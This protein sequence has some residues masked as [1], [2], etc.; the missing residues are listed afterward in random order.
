VIQLVLEF[1]LLKKNFNVKLFWRN[2][3]TMKKI[4]SVTALIVLSLTSCKK[5]GEYNNI[6]KGV[7]YGC[8][9]NSFPEISDNGKSVYCKKPKPPNQR[10]DPTGTFEPVKPGVPFFNDEENYAIHTNGKKF[11]IVR[12]SAA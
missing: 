4:L 12:N 11:Y 1:A 9:D 3:K 6:K 10:P 8:T 2:P 5:T 7:E